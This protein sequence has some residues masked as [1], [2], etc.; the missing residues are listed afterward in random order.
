MTPGDGGGGQFYSVISQSH[1]TTSKDQLLSLMTNLWHITE[2]LFK[3]QVN[4]E[5]CKNTRKWIFWMWAKHYRIYFCCDFLSCRTSSWI[6][7]RICRN[8]KSSKSGCWW[9]VVQKFNIIIIFIIVIIII[10]IIIFFW[11][12]H[13][14]KP[15]V[16]LSFGPSYVEKNKNITLP[17]CHVTSYPPAVITWSKGLGELIQARAVSKD[18]QLSITNAQK[19]DSGL[20]K[21][22]A[23]NILGYDSAVT[24][25]SVVELPQ[26][27]ARPPE[28]LKELLNRNITIPCRATGDPKPT[29]TWVKEN[30]ELPLGRSTVSVDG[31]L[32]IWNTKEED[33]GRYTCVAA[34]AVKFKALSVM[35]LT[36]TRGRIF[37]A[38][39]S[40]T[41]SFTRTFWSLYPAW[42]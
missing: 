6:R 38:H 26:F 10:I 25:L 7:E 33:S 8:S 23:T 37:H 42:L 34:S 36:V 30:G 39:H 27:T 35:K 14:G 29:V 21:C 16:S 15:K 4:W 20:Y 1:R 28:Q 31:T 40:L 24:H 41:Y 9:R 17:T 11:N 32:Q 12:F 3:V 2:P 18:G 19:K 13:P 22:K 5:S